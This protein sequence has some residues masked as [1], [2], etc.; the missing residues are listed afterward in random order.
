[1]H[2]NPGITALLCWGQNEFEA[3]LICSETPNQLNVN[4]LG[5]KIENKKAKTRGLVLENQIC[6]RLR[7]EMIQDL[8]AIGRWPLCENG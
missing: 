5:V 8:N 7:K 4:H 2:A 1:M 3:S 6:Q